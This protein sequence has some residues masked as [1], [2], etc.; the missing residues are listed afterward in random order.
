[1]AYYMGQA[2]YTAEALAALIR[3]PQNRR[4]VVKETIEKLGGRLEGLWFAFGEYDVVLIMEIPDN[5]TAT[6]FSL[7]V[8]ASGSLKDFK[9]TPLMT[10]EEA[11]DA[12]KK[13][14]E[15]GYRPPAG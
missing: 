12:M 3:N 15:A 9:T 10:A 1:M 6:A 4:E 7:A 5:V 8:A 2:A 13:A 11:M 14:G